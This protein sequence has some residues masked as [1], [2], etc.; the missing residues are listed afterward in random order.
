MADLRCAWASPG[1]AIVL[2]GC[3]SGEADPQVPPEAE[4][5]LALQPSTA[6]LREVRGDVRYQK[7]VAPA[8]QAAESGQELWPADA[9]Q[10]M[11]DGRTV[12][13]FR[14]GASA[15]LQPETTLRIPSQ[16]PEVAHLRHLAGRMQAILT[17]EGEVRRME[18]ALPPGTLVLERPDA[19][20]ESTIVEA[21]LAIHGDITEIAMLEG[22]GKLERS[23][24]RD[25]PIPSAHRVA[26]RSDGELLEE[27]LLGDPVEL[28]SPASGETVRTRRAV[29]FRWRAHSSAESYRLEIRREGAEPVVRVTPDAVADVELVSG[30]YRW[31]VQGLVGG[32]LL[33]RAVARELRVD[34]DRF[35]P[36]L[37]IDA[38]VDGATLRTPVVRVNG[39]SEPGARVAVDGQP[40]PVRPDGR[41][42]TQH[43]VR[44]GL[45][46][47]V[48]RASDDLGNVRAVSRTVLLD[49]P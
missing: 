24:S 42:S 21:R 40:I 9:V 36:P 17:P 16:E 13:V 1:L 15:R 14:N 48:I 25:V 31:Q 27:S 8:W 34:L 6:H 18:V 23:S 22:E 43:R 5:M 3:G 39:R 28:E 32:E 41:F 20:A 26:L 30:D 38:P 45:S 4:T 35:S 46:N 47:I 10:T 11:E 12:V 33:P 44:A 7:P 49:V 19:S 37:A 2:L 29:S